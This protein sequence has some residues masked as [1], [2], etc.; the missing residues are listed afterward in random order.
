ML[1]LT[2]TAPAHGG[3]A[4]GHDDR[5]RAIFVPFAL[6][7]ET[8][9]VRLVEESGR[10]AHAELIEVVESSPDRVKTRCRHFG[11]CGGCHW[12]HAGY[13]AQLQ[14]KREIVTDQLQRLGNIQDANV[15][16][17][18]SLPESYDNQW[19]T[20]LSP[21]PG[22]GLGY[23]SPVKQQVFA[24][25]ECPVLDSRLEALVHDFTL[26]LPELRKLT[27]RLGD[28]E[29]LLAALEIHGVEAPELEVDFP[30]SVALVLPDRTAVTLIG[31]PTLELTI[32]GRRFRISPGIGYAANPAAA[33]LMIDA[34]LEFAALTGHETVLETP[35][36]S[37]LLTAFLGE[38]A[39]NLL[40]IE[41]NPDAVADLVVNLYDLNNIA[42]YEGSE[43]DILPNLDAAADLIVTHR[44]SGGLSATLFDALG[45]LAPPRFIYAS[46]S[47]AAFASDARR[48]AQTGYRLAA[49]QPIDTT[50]H[51][52]RIDTIAL[53]QR[54]PGLSTSPIM[55]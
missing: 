43:E 16:P 19:E 32:K 10:F 44:L 37:G 54:L 36:G 42:L 7:G 18:R 45:R 21:V 53:F 48:L 4:V 6:P 13:P 12:Q 52:F 40:A 31:D 25:G 34:I 9:R 11:I 22:G 2:L 26:D 5:G 51:H 30:V 23:W 35:A 14:F 46:S 3:N 50:P 41:Q 39:A 55:R 29:T 24:I 49:V 20:V 33:G 27:L 17:V 15:L 1:T 38:A 28:E 8:V 47:L